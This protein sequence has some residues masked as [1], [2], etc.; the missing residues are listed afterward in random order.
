MG[1]RRR[2]HVMTARHGVNIPTL[3]AK[4]IISLIFLTSGAMKIVNP[5]GFTANVESF[6]IF[7]HFLIPAIV[8]TIP[9]L[10]ILAGILIH[11]RRMGGPSALA[12]TGLSTGFLLLY[13]ATLILGITPDCGCFGD[14]PFLQVTPVSGF[15]RAVA[16]TA[17]TGGVWAKSLTSTKLSSIHP[18]HK[19]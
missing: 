19:E 18:P 14:N 7:P 16:L 8:A 3:L 12:L 15:W 13:A 17:L 2:A 5:D 1:Y 6:K 10:E 11:T 9:L 4:G